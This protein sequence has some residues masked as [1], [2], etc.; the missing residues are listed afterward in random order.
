[1]AVSRF[2]YVI[3]A[4]L[5]T[6]NNLILRLHSRQ[7]MHYNFRG[8]IRGFFEQNRLQCRMKPENGFS[9]KLYI[10]EQHTIYSSL[11]WIFCSNLHHRKK[12]L[13][14]VLAFACAFTMFAGAAFTDAAD[15]N[16]DNVEAVDLLTTLNIIGGYPDGTFDPEGTVDRAEMAKMIY[17]I[18]NDGNTDASA[19]VDNSTSFTDIN[20]HWA[21]G[22]IKYLQ[23]T[24]I[25]SG[26]SAT[27]F[28]PDAPVT[29]TEAMKMALVLAGY[30]ATNAELT[31]VNWSKNTLTLATTIGLTDN[32]HSAMTAGCTRQD[33]AQILANVLSATAVRYSSIVEDFV[34]DSKDGLAF[35]GPAI[36][37]GNKWMDLCTDIGVLADLDNTTLSIIIDANDAPDS[38]H[39]AGKQTFTKITKDYTELLGQKVKVLFKNGKN[40]DV[41]G[42]Y[43]VPDNEVLTVYQNEIDAENAKIKIDGTLY[44]LESDGV[45]V[46][47]DGVQ[48]SDNWHAVDFKDTLS[49]WV[50]TLV[51]TDDNNKID[52][53]VIKTVTVAQVT[54]VST[55]QI[56][57]DG[58]T[59]KFADESIDENVAV[60]DY[61][62]I[63]ENLYNEN[64]DIAVVA[65]QTG[66]VEAT[67]GT[68]PY[69]D[70]QI[71]GT[72]YK[73][74]ADNDDI[75]AAVKAGTDAEYVVV[76][77]ILFYAK[78]V[79]GA[80]GKLA[81]IVFVSYVGT[82]GLNDDQV[83]VMYPDGKVATLTYDKDDS[84]AVTP[85]NFYEYEVTNGVYELHT[86]EIVNNPNPGDNEN[87]YGDYTYY[88]KKDLATVGSSATTFNTTIIDDNADV[89]VFASNG[90]NTS[91]KHIT[92]KQL[93]N[94]NLVIGTTQGNATTNG[95][96]QEV[97]LGGFISEVDGFDR[98]TVIAVRYLST[99]GEF[100]P[101]MSGLESNSNYGFIISD[102]VKVEGGIR[103]DMLTA[104]SDTPVTVIA[105]RNTV[106]NFDK[107]RV[108]GYS[109]LTETEGSEY[110]TINDPTIILGVNEG[111]SLRAASITATNGSNKVSTVANA[112]MELDDFTTVIYTNSYNNTID[113]VVDGTPRK[114]KDNRTNI[115]Y[116][117]GEV[118]IIDANQ[119]VGD[120]YADN[121]VTATGFADSASVQ[122]TDATTGE[123][124]AKSERGAYDNAVL[125]VSITT[126][127]S[128]TVTLTNGAATA[129]Y[130]IVANEP[131]KIDGII[132]D[133]NVDV[134]FN[135]ATSVATGVDAIKNAI[136]SAFNG[137]ATATGTQANPYTLTKALTD[138]ADLNDGASFDVAFNYYED[139]YTTTVAATGDVNGLRNDYGTGEYS[140]ELIS[141]KLI[142][143]DVADT[144]PV[145]ANGKQMGLVFTITEDATGT[146]TKV[147]ALITLDTTVADANAAQKVN[148]DLV[149][150][151]TATSG[152]GTSFLDGA[153]AVGSLENV[154]KL[155][156]N[157]SSGADVG[158]AL[159][160]AYDDTKV[161]VEVAAVEEADKPVDGTNLTGTFE[162]A[163]A[164]ALNAGKTAVNVTASGVSSASNW[165][166][167]T[168]KVTAKDV[169]NATTDQATVTYTVVV[170]GA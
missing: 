31:G 95:N 84:V 10:P 53:A 80:S 157:V 94:N 74:A 36:S 33:A 124:W 111:G 34:N 100:G 64:K 149:A 152:N 170:Y 87:Y 108:V 151:L 69:T 163:S 76:N 14:L 83:R 88:G 50:I 141:G 47:K 140:A 51:D 65:K 98:A 159:S 132:V 6:G 153:T 62:T 16:A 20:G 21:E 29:T 28:D 154:V 118:A 156:K 115:L 96:I 38:H 155:V 44:A 117:N 148:N 136:K 125:N 60:D 17:T 3:F 27:I 71:D 162:K 93:K 43:A 135:G 142:I 166:A 8:A 1:M 79:S 75:N 32:V 4:E 19:H 139:G 73:A 168:L 165:T 55:T 105:D 11:K 66:S 90:T 24:G 110:L 49:P 59:Y 128:G 22:Y 102:A 72:W 116:I 70:Y 164:V 48:E 103:F 46:V 97:S 107:G 150:T 89:I 131:L 42:V 54:F 63:T 68:T 12:I 82:S 122:W 15:I 39:D 37:V 144:A 158:T 127:T 123:T 57:A 30:D 26:K 92:G 61:V 18:R 109:S 143:K 126:K 23:N 85:G 137:T 119:I 112:E 130:N 106:A 35:A 99:D 113:K 77:N 56:I 81:D 121:A 160:S 91:V 40:N 169:A 101:N 120:V 104:D 9:K 167:Y 58:K 13:A 161:D 86:P 147:Y 52:F 41:I 129:T 145:F 45:E 5:S 133:G 134:A 7:N 2:I 25:V 138:A 78:K 114:A 67:K 146:Q